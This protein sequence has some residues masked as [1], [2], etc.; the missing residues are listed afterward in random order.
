M[1]PDDDAHTVQAVLPADSAWAT[2]TRLAP[3][4]P[5]QLDLVW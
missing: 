4:M 5:E 2:V 3:V 1:R